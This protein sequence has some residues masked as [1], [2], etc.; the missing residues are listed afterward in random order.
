M[1]HYCKNPLWP[2]PG[3]IKAVSSG[4]IINLITSSEC[5]YLGDGALGNPSPVTTH[6]CGCKSPSY[7]DA[8]VRRDSFSVENNDLS[9][10]PSFPCF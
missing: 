9:V 10:G 6:S 2:I 7:L 5:H 8:G 4:A 1:R 3:H